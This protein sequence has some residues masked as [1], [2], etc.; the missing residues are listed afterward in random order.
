MFSV[1]LHR[2]KIN[3]KVY[4]GITSQEPKYRW[5]D[6]KGY[7]HN[8]YFT[9]AIN[10]YGWNNFEHVILYNSLSESEACLKE[11]EL[12]QKYNSNSHDFGYNLESGGRYFKVNNQT[13]QKISNFNKG[14]IVSEEI[15]KKISNTEKGKKLS[16]ETK[17]KI[18]EASKKRF[19]NPEERR[20][21]SETQ[22]RVRKGEVHS[23]EWNKHVSDAL[24]GRKWIN[25][26]IIQKFVF[27]DELNLYLEQG[28]KL[29]K[30]TKKE[31]N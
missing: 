17:K 3:N 12:I 30:L 23:S 2:N 18:S 24:K 20:K 8:L 7:K 26:N 28:F 10:K 11:K 27:K 19:Q 16:E 1:Y 14:K 4:I 29:G 31:D 6:G 9:Q 22:K 15:R 13:K 5:N 25:N 21:I